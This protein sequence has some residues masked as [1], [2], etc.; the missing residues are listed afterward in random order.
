MVQSSNTAQE[1]DKAGKPVGNDSKTNTSP[2]VDTTSAVVTPITKEQKAEAAKAEAAARKA[3]AEAQRAAEAAKKLEEQD[4][5][6][7]RVKGKS[8]NLDPNSDVAKDIKAFEE[9]AMAFLK[10]EALA[11]VEPA[12]LK[13]KIRENIISILGMSKDGQIVSDLHLT[14]GFEKVG[15]L[16]SKDGPYGKAIGLMSEVDTAYN[17]YKSG[18]SGSNDSTDSVIARRT[19]LTR[20][21]YDALSE[22]QRAEH[23]KIPLNKG[24]ERRSKAEIDSGMSMVEHAMKNPD[25]YEWTSGSKLIKRINELD[26]KT[27]LTNKEKSELDNLTKRM[28]E[29]S[30]HFVAELD[31]AGGKDKI[32]PATGKTNLETLKEDISTKAD[33]LNQGLVNE[34]GGSFKQEALKASVSDYPQA[35]IFV[36]SGNFLSPERA[37]F[38]ATP[39]TQRFVAAKESAVASLDSLAANLQDLDPRI[40]AAIKERRPVEIPGLDPKNPSKDFN[41]LVNQMKLSDRDKALLEIVNLTFGKRTINF[42]ANQGPK[43]TQITNNVEIGAFEMLAVANYSFVEANKDKKDVSFNNDTHGTQRGRTITAFGPYGDSGKFGPGVLEA[44]LKVLADLAKDPKLLESKEG[45]GALKK[46]SQEMKLN[47]A[48]MTN[49]AFKNGAMHWR[50]NVLSLDEV[51]NG[52]IKP[53]AENIAAGWVFQ[54]TGI[55]DFLS[56]ALGAKGTIRN[57]GNTS[58]GNGGGNAGGS[59]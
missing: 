46:A 7:G 43:G 55:S 35:K 9:K 42:S 28:E 1:T 24:V 44:Q 57:N 25:M 22:E 13:Q 26:S 49:T 2:V 32:D 48:I 14:G 47:E 58:G 3:A 20:K 18:L 33:T 40:A 12:E 50:D 52:L 53:L 38:L 59:F 23:L 39:S 8:A 10:S 31:S 16:F 37:I 5:R 15:A 6:L 17:N 11:N 41:H 29:V 34:Q 30:A 56:N 51:T 21:E 54:Q 19:G 36:D 27:E 45:L 4:S